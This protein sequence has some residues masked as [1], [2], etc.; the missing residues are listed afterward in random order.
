MISN[1]AGFLNR[2]RYAAVT[3]KNVNPASAEIRLCLAFVELH[4]NNFDNADEILSELSVY[5]NYYKQA[6]APVYAAHVFLTATH[7]ILTGKASR[8][9]RRMR[10]VNDLSGALSESAISLLSGAFEAERGNFNEA[11]GFFADCHNKNGNSVF[12]Y[13][14]LYRLFVTQDHIEDKQGLFFPFLN[15]SLNAG[16]NLQLTADHYRDSVLRSMT[17][18][19]AAERLYKTYQF[20]WLLKYI[21]GELAGRRDFSLKSHNYFKQAEYRQLDLNDLDLYLL[22]ASFINKKEDV[23]RHTIENYLKRRDKNASLEIFCYHLIINDEKLSDLVAAEKLIDFAA[24]LLD[25]GGKGR[26]CNSLYAL[27]VKEAEKYNVARSVAQRAETVLRDSLFDYEAEIKNAEAKFIWVFEE[28]KRD[29]GVFAINDGKAKIKA[30]GDFKYVLT[31]ASQKNILAETRGVIFRKM[32]ENADEKLLLRYADKTPVDADLYI[33]LSAMYL[34]LPAA[35]DEAVDILN[36]ALSFKNISQGFRM[37]LAATLGNLLASK[38]R[39]DK[40]MEYYNLV[41]I[42][43]LNEK[44]IEQ[45]LQAFARAGYY[46]E[47]VELIVKKPHCISERSMFAAIKKIAAA[48]T[49]DPEIADAAYELLL[50]S[51][52]DKVFIDIVIRHYNGGQEEWQELARSLAV[53]GVYDAEIDKKIIL[54]GIWM[55]KPDPGSQRVFLRMA[56]ASPENEMNGWYVYY[57]I[58]EILINN[59]RPEYETIDYLEKY[60][61]EKED[62]YLAY[63]L[64]SFY[65]EQ[66]VQTPRSGEIIE[67][68]LDFMQEDGILLPSVLNL[69]DKSAQRPYILKNQPFMYR[70]L[71][72][73]QVYLNYRFDSEETTRRIK[74]KYLRYGLY[75]KVL[76]VFYGEKIT[77]RYSE[78]MDSGSVST[79]D[80]ESVNLRYHL[81]ENAEEDYFKLNNAFIY[82]HMFKYDQVEKIITDNIQNVRMIKGSLL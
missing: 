30:A 31:D 2:A 78:E 81:N 11:Y 33:G 4:L 63:A 19:R 16:M 68:A 35:P 75:A 23:R 66:S 60:F 1:D 55:H 62:K 77:Y 38:D 76:P 20:N 59:F 54:N 61:A 74:M 52:Y 58:Y 5:K 69:K 56:A 53:I 65:T 9:K 42:N 8:A 28:V 17:G 73:R 18:V 80:Y 25:K 50:K 49:H 40:A 43:Y 44:Y 79:P 70:A 82:E 22:T 71:P 41:D 48:G 67:R 27:L 34:N 45:M 15:W 13:I 37:R 46:K 14:Y 64:F 12:L 26:H 39:Y 29:K 21:C 24:G 72:E 7:D 10:A 32:I 51:W 47:A 6:D 36:T 57:L 3:A